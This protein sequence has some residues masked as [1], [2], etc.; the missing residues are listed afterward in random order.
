MSIID[1][2]LKKAQQKR[3]EKSDT[4]EMLFKKQA[5]TSGVSPSPL[6]GTDKNADSHIFIPKISIPKIGTI[7]PLIIAAALALLLMIGLALILLVRAGSKPPARQEAKE[8]IETKAA[9]VAKADVS[10]KGQSPSYLPQERVTLPVVSGIMYSPRN[11]QAIV[12]GMLVSEG[13][14]V[15]SFVLIKIL[16]DTV[17]V[18]HGEMEYNLKLR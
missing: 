6:P 11:P 14:T 10:S 8:T 5:P 3:S 16:P 1:D 15:D 7:N 4:S 18:K 12:N 9:P 17:R 13:S 2:A